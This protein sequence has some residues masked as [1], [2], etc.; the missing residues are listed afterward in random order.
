MAR[1]ECSSACLE[2]SGPNT[3]RCRETFALHHCGCNC[4][5]WV[6]GEDGRVCTLTGRVIGSLDLVHQHTGGIANPRGWQVYHGNRVSPL[7]ESTQHQMRIIIET[8]EAIFC[9][10]TRQQLYA[11]VLAR[12]KDQVS[13]QMRRG[14]PKTVRQAISIAA[15]T[16]LRCRAQSNPPAHPDAPWIHPL[17]L[18]IHRIWTEVRDELV[19]VVS[20]QSLRHFTAAVVSIMSAGGLKINGVSV[21]GTHRACQAH[22]LAELQYRDVL[23]RPGAGKRTSC[24]NR[25]H[26]MTRQLWGIATGASGFA[27]T[28]D[29]A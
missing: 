5:R 21:I 2:E 18:R 17:A 16:L 19:P 11:D 10:Q 28:L 14:G 8:V 24:S 1:H 25:I 15:K 20:S 6:L 9:G 29:E 23:R 12:C 7:R 3:F 4:T 13:K 22:A 26:K 27:R